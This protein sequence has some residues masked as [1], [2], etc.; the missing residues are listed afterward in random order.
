[1]KSDKK[2]EDI[3]KTNIK[4]IKGD[5]SV[6]S[7]IIDNPYKGKNEIKVDGLFIDIGHIPLSELAKKLGVTLNKREEIVID[8]RTAETNIEG[9]FAAGDVTDKEFKQLITGIADGCTA[10][11]YAH[12][13][14][15]K[16]QI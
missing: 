12:E 14:L 10:A 11:Y 6:K 13:Y 2:I 3:K 7:I 8:A 1:M 4:E 5:K 9:V 16:K 15:M